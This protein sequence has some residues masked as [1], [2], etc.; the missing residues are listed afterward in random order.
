MSDDEISAESDDEM[1]DA[2]R[3]AFGDDAVQDL[4]MSGTNDDAMSLEQ[5]VDEIDRE[6]SANV[7]ASAAS[8]RKVSNEKTRRYIAVELGK[9]L[10]GIPMDNVY[11]IQRVPQVTSLP[12]VPEW[13]QGVCNLRG[14]VLSVVD[15]STL[16]GLPMSQTPAAN[17][18][19]VV[20][21]SL[22]DEVDTG[23]VVDRVMG[24]RSFAESTII[25]PTAAIDPQIDEYLNGVVESDELFALLDVEKLLLS[26][27]FR[28]FDA[29]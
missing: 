12:G 8:R 18:R 24:I 15:L 23:F 2:I 9:T 10:F 17:Q 22:V 4:D 1:L 25:A 29:A 7:Q 16:L 20:T 13:V 27:Q 5:L 19:L 6:A 26:E 28:Q 3:A 11:E 14:N 21:Q